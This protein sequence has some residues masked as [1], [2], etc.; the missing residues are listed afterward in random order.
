MPNVVGF[1]RVLRFSPPNKTG[2]HNKAE[3]L[4]TVASNPMQRKKLLSTS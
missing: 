2:R 1:N 4:L 3:K